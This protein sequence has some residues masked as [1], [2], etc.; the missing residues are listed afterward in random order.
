MLS[1]LEPA[2]MFILSLV[3][4]HEVVSIE[5]LWSFALIWAG[6]GVMIADAWL[7]NRRSKLVAVNG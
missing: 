2:L 1:Y 7:Q 6:I 4:L 5:A 3:V